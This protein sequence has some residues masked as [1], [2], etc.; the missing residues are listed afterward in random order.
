M[1]LDLISPM[2][3]THHLLSEPKVVPYM[4]ALQDYDE[5]HESS[6]GCPGDGNQSK[7]RHSHAGC[8]GRVSGIN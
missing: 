3:P 2:L 4:L 6:R 7:K 8:V 5:I 1:L